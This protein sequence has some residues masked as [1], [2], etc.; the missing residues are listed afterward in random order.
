MK[1]RNWFD[2]L[3]QCQHQGQA[4]VLITVINTAGS[5]PREMGSKM[6]V[7][8]ES[9]FDTIGGGHMEFVII[10]R[11][12]ELLVKGIECH[13]IESFPLASRVG[14]CCGGA[15]KVLYEVHYRHNQ[16]LA[17]FGGGHV[18]QAL[19]PILEQL[20]LQIRWFDSRDTLPETG[21]ITPHIPLTTSADPVAEIR[22]LPE[23][24]WVLILTHNHQLDYQLVQQALKHAQLDF[25]G[26]IGSQTK[27]KRFR[28]RLEHRGFTSEQIA[29]LISPVGDLSVPGK[30]PIEV[31]VSISAQ[32]IQR[33]NLGAAQSVN[34]QSMAETL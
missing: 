2:A 19:V 11:A 29:Q 24:S 3:H 17:V 13:Q 7:T 20:P 18:A 34:L 22:D 8:G 26:M 16:Q 33:L 25:I 30:R 4:Y 32:L 12:R 6:V 15:M 23:G 14:Q 5:T 28:L 1:A 9:Q 21:E 27:A 10:Q 31:A